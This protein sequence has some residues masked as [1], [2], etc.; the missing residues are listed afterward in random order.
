MPVFFLD[1]DIEDL[2]IV[3][4]T[5]QYNISPYRLLPRHTYCKNNNFITEHACLK[6]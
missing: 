1:I 5:L 2:F 6:I 3:E 4:Y